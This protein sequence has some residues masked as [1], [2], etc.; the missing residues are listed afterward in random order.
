[1]I[2][3]ATA[4]DIWLKTDREAGR[5]FVRPGG[6]WTVSR[7]AELDGA[8]RGLAGAVGTSAVIDLAHVEAL[9]TAGAW[10]LHRTGAALNA[11]GLKV[12]FANVKEGQKVLLKQV[13][14]AIAPAAGEKVL[15]KQPLAAF[16]EARGRAVARLAEGVLMGLSF[17]GLSVLV[18]LRSLAL[19][20]RL[21]LTA[22]VHHMKQVGFN[23][24]PIV[25]L[26]TFLIGVVL[27]YLGSKQLR[28]FGADIFIVDL[29]SIAT[30]REV[31]ILLMAVVVAGRS[32][33]AFTAEIGAMKVHEEIDAMRTLG[34]DPMEVLVI[35]RVL[36]MVIMLPGLLFVADMMGLLG[37]VMLCWTILDISPG[38]F[39]E[40][41]RDGTD[42]WSFWV[43]L[44]KAPIL[45][46]IIALVGC[47]QGLQVRGSAESVGQHT[48]TSVVQ[49]IFLVI[50][51]DA[52]FAIFFNVVG[53]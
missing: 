19:P 40:R 8:L 30:L 21:R 48:T 50:T 22:L 18:L 29:V 51:V 16:L 26:L 20:G 44:I 37:G 10:L 13:E 7:I 6:S 38:L 1:M 49:S 4:N 11:A 17:L 52:F 5:L 33:S 53:V 14:S 43:G 45:G 23:A 12:E 41:L 25:S 9:D 15:K 36:A 34:L 35:P 42:L 28:E 27:A 32:G 31:G 47:Y 39:V 46:A 3:A 2:R 24:V